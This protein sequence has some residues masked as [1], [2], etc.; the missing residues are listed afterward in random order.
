M[1]PVNDTYSKSANNFSCLGPCTR[2]GVSVIHP[3]T[4]KHIT[5]NDHPFCPVNEWEY[6]N[7]NTQKTEIKSTDKCYNPIRS[8]TENTYEIAMNII[9]PQ[10]EFTN[11]RFLKIYYNIYSMENALEWLSDNTEKSFITQKRVLDASWHS[12]GFSSYILDDRLILFYIN[13][14]KKTRIEYIYDKIFDKLKY[15]NG[16]II[17]KKNIDDYDYKKKEK[18]EFIKNKLIDFNNYN[19]FLNQY[20]EKYK[21]KQSKVNSHTDNIILLFEDYLEKKIEISL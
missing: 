20:I 19:K 10:I 15:D 3:I 4:L 1:N 14:T 11:E 18:I 21:Q 9:T 5:D 2:P 8:K 13:L 17:L 16:N 12:Y 7:P 6:F